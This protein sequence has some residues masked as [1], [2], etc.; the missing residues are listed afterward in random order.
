LLSKCSRSRTR[1]TFLEGQHAESCRISH[2]IIYNSIIYLPAFSC[3]APL[4]TRIVSVPAAS[5]ASIL[6]RR[7]FDVGQNALCPLQTRLNR[8]CLRRRVLLVHRWH[9]QR[10]FQRCQTANK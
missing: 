2:T 6:R 1:P 3:D 9:Q 10:L 7:V 8:R 5:E 4:Y